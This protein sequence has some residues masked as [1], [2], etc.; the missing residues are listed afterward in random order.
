[1][2]DKPMK[3]HINIIWMIC[4]Q[5][6]S[7]YAAES[8]VFPTEKN[9]NEYGTAIAGKEVRQITSNGNKYLLYLPKDYNSEKEWPLV[10][11]LHGSTLRGDSLSNLEGRTPVYQTIQFPFLL[12]SPLCPLDTIWHNDLIEPIFQDV[13]KN[14]SINENKI[15]V[16][17]M[18]MGAFGAVK[19]VANNPDRFAGYIPVAG[20]Y[21]LNSDSLPDNICDFS[22]VP[23]WFIHGAKDVNVLPIQSQ[24]VV[25]A[26][27]E[28]GGEPQFTLY[29][30]ADHIETLTKVYD[31]PETVIYE[32][33]VQQDRSK[34]N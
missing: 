17:G 1:M 22:D 26:L 24:Q 14:Y 8:S 29:P 5:V 18:S 12:V 11:F 33:L 10:F 2:K 6:L 23:A 3:I 9:T 13:M 21:I 31:D 34:R 27:K 16:T 32:W 28:C 30:N 7:C 20:G 15:T 19:L 25:D 4:L